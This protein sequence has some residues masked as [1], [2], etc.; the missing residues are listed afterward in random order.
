M[1]RLRRK[2]ILAAI[3]AAA[4]GTSCGTK[5]PNL[6]PY[7][8]GRALV[9]LLPDADGSV[10][11]ASVSTPTGSAELS[12]AR[13]SVQATAG[14]P[15][16]PVATLSQ[17]DVDRIFGDALSAL[18][19]APQHFTLFF[20]FETDELTEESRALV[21]QIQKAVAERPM[22][23]IIVVGHT[24][25]M[26]TPSANFE[27][28]LKRART[29]RNLLSVSGLDPSTIEVTSLGETDLLVKT[30]DETSEPRNRRV[31]IAVR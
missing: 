22:P 4:V 27:L 30:P 21:P 5:R 13:E 19:P 12:G 8:S 18:P 3:V 15:L 31:E 14:Q 10:G 20:Q 6:T 28:G 17:E 26:G 29:V 11:R 24:D 9:A 25:T 2:A 16:G 23:D 1:A 7:P